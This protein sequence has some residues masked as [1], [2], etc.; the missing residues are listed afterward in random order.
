MSGRN[1]A[2]YES[3]FLVDDFLAAVFLGAA[4]FFTAAGFL[5]SAMLGFAG[6]AGCSAFT[7]FGAAF[8]ALASGGGP[9]GSMKTVFMR[10]RIRCAVVR[11]RL[12]LRP[13]R[14]I[15][16]SV[17]LSRNSAPGLPGGRAEPRGY[18]NCRSTGF[19]EVI[20]YNE[21]AWNANTHPS[22]PKCEFEVKSGPS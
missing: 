18:L 14:S 12:G 21:P 1:L 8:F 5:D 6:G 10:P 22:V 16:I 4:G 13:L 3:V 2:S 11:W 17:D 7:G 15:P 19:C 20:H 9:S